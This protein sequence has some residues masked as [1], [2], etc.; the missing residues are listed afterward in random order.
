MPYDVANIEPG[1]YYIAI[2]NKYLL[3][4][5]MDTGN[6]VEKLELSALCEVMLDHANGV[7]NNTFVSC[8]FKP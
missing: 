8:S 6:V 7:K 3:E 5:D 4:R 2:T 1:E